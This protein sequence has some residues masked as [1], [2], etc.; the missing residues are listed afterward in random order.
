MIFLTPLSI[1][2]IIVNHYSKYCLLPLFKSMMKWTKKDKKKS[3][4]VLKLN[5]N[6]SKLWSLKKEESTSLSV[7]KLFSNMLILNIIWAA[8]LTVPPQVS[9]LSKS[10]SESNFHKRMSSCSDLT[11]LMKNKVTKSVSMPHLEF[12]T[13][14]RNATYLTAFKECS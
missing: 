4:S 5:K 14:K 13:L 9:V 3:F 2:P 11:E 7:I 8:Q 12:I 6:N 1:S 10:N